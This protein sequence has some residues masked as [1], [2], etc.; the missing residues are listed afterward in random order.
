LSKFPFKAKDAD[1]S[2]VKQLIIQLE[3]DGDIYLDAIKIVK[4]EK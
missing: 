4:N 1:V 3:A 2:K